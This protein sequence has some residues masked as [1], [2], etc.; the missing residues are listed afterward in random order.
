MSFGTLSVPFELL[1]R[2]FRCIITGNKTWIHQSEPKSRYQSLEWKHDA[3]LVKE[4]F[5]MQPTAGRVMLTVFLD[6]HGLMLEHGVER[7]RG[8]QQ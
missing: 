7:G 5:R 8:I 1:L 3:S 6:L 4:K 2:A